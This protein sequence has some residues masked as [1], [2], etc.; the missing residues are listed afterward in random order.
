M[1]EPKLLEHDPKL[2]REVF[3]AARRING[4]SPVTYRRW[5]RDYVDTMAALLGYVVLD[6]HR[7]ARLKE[8]REGAKT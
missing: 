8:E 6:H 4:W 2:A 3:E 5:L 1:T 7:A